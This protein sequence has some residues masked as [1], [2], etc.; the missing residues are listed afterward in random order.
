MPARFRRGAGDMAPAAQS[1]CVGLAEAMDVPSSSSMRTLE[2]ARLLVV[3]ETHAHALGAATRGIGRRDPG[4]LAG[5]RK[6]LRDP[7]AATA[8]GRCLRPAVFTRGGHEEAPIGEQRHVGGVQRALLAEHQLDH[9]GPSAGSRSRR[10]GLHERAE[11]AGAGGSTVIHE[12][13]VS[14]RSP[15]RPGGAAKAMAPAVTIASSSSPSF[16][17]C[18]S[19]RARRASSCCQAPAAPSRAEPGTRSAAKKR[20]G[21]PAARA[22]ASWQSLCSASS[23]RGSRPAGKGRR[24]ATRHRLGQAAPDLGRHPGLRQRQR[25]QRPAAAGGQQHLRRGDALPGQP[26]AGQRRP[27]WQGQALAAAAHG[28]QQQAGVGGV[29]SSRVPAG[30]SSRVFSRALAAL[31]V[32]RLGRVQ[33]RHLAAPAGAGLVDPV[34]QAAGFVDADLSAGLALAVVALG[35]VVDQ[36]PGLLTAQLS[37]ASAPAGRGARA[38]AQPATAAAAAGFAHDPPG[39]VRTTRPCP[40][41]GQIPAR[42][43]RARRAAAW[44]ARAATAA[45]GPAV[46]PARAGAVRH[47]DRRPG[48]AYHHGRRFQFGQDLLPHGVDRRAR[49]C[50][51]KRPGSASCNARRSRRSRVRRRPDPGSRTGRAP[52][53]PR[54]AG[55]R[56]PAAG[57]ARASGRAAGPAGPR[58]SSWVSIGGR[59]RARRPGRQRWHR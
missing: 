31:R 59:S 44:R 21:A 22:I 10:T 38:T 49:R 12:A 7:R 18:S 8:A 36:R 28:G 55:P 2:V 11:A 35:L 52:A 51:A 3:R 58:L 30:G 23:T 46:R 47:S 20:V 6:A 16:H 15:A 24:L 54:G 9:A 39:G 56:W 5:H 57:P 4:H 19:W 17:G 13:S 45:R 50:L 48:F 34:H 33:H 43:R 14:K 1:V 37:R 32:Q 29:S 42:P 26:G 53:P 40:A 41:R 27:A 25:I